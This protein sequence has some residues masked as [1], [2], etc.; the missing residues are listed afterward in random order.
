MQLLLL[1]AG[2][3]L[4]WLAVGLAGLLV[5]TQQGEVESY[6]RKQATVLLQDMADRIT[7]LL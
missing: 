6:Q 1:L 7:A 3:R 5:T 2:R 4:F